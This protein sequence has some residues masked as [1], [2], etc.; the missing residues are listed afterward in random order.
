MDIEQFKICSFSQWLLNTEG[1]EI[2]CS[3]KFTLQWLLLQIQHGI[4]VWYN[5][6]VGTSCES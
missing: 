3:K 1:T 4:G 2:L 6:D 5:S